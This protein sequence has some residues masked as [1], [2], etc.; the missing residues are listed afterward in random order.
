MD[1]YTINSINVNIIN[2]K[3]IQY[4]H[5]CYN[6]INTNNVI[7]GNKMDINPKMEIGKRLWEWMK[8]NPMSIYNIGRKI[9]ITHVTILRLLRG[10]TRLKADIIIKIENFLDS[11]KTC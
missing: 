6:V 1:K 5:I 11:Q 2:I 8:D 9:G 10:A 4:H 3:S 7:K